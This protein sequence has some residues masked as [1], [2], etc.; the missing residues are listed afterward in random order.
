MKIMCDECRSYF[1]LLADDYKYM[2]WLTLSIFLQFLES[3]GDI[4]HETFEKMFGCLMTFREYAM[5]EPKEADMDKIPKAIES[6]EL[7]IGD[8]VIKTHVLDDGTRII[9]ADSLEAFFDYLARGGTL[10]RAD[11]DGVAKF[12]HG[13]P[14]RIDNSKESNDG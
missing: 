13:F 1:G 8:V 9:E 11:A 3:E 14:E 12:V 10:S 5:L 7:K 2:D 4:E 6:G